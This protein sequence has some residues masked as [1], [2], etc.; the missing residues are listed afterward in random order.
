MVDGQ[1]RSS[2]CCDK[3]A[4][5]L[6]PGSRW[7]MSGII[8]LLKSQFD[9]NMLEEAKS[10]NCPPPSPLPQETEEVWHGLKHLTNFSL[11]SMARL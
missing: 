11:C 10:P 8:L 5:N 3:D 9:G 2:A 4:E 7:S 6:A 1:E